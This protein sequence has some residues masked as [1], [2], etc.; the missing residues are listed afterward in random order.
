MIEPLPTD[1]A[2]GSLAGLW[3]RQEKKQVHSVV[4]EGGSEWLEQD[5]LFNYRII[6]QGIP[7]TFP[8]K[9]EATGAF[10]TGFRTVTV[11]FDK[12]FMRLDGDPNSAGEF[13]FAFGAG[14]AETKERLGNVEIYGDETSI[15]DGHTEQ[16]DK[17]ITIPAAPRRLWAQVNALE[18]DVYH[19]PFD[20]GFHGVGMGAS[21]DPPGTYGWEDE[22]HAFASVTEHFDISQTLEGSLETP[23][24]M[25]TGSFAIAFN[26]HGRL[27][28]IPRPGKWLT[29]V[30]K[31]THSLRRPEGFRK[32]AS[33]SIWSA[34]PGQSAVVTS[35]HGH[36][37]RVVLDPD[38]AVYHQE[39][40]KDPRAWR[41]AP[42][43][44]LGGRFEGPLTVVAVG[45]ERVNLFGLSPEGAVL[46]KSHAPDE[47]PDEDWHTLGGDFV[48]PVVA[49]TGADEAIELFATSEDGSVFH[50][51]LAHP[52][53]KQPRG[54]WER[55]GDGI[56]GS[57]AAL[58]S[59][60]T[61]LSLF[62]LG[63]GGEVLHKRRPPRKEQWRPADREWETLGLASGGL[64]SAEWV[65][66]EG[67]L[68][69][70]V[71]QDET[72]RVLAWSAYPE[73]P[74]SEGWQIIGTVNSL[75]QTQ[76]KVRHRLTA[77][78]GDDPGPFSARSEHDKR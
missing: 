72:V 54:E 69:A 26:V 59:P 37:H 32:R 38:G 17:G 46:H 34:R 68:L 53:R 47:R 75:L 40:G 25:S 21:F 43:T 35:A 27:R 20:A 33:R 31:V 74:P 78:A 7:G 48:G 14:D 24:T 13:T 63:R 41:D 36:P 29:S 12:I 44:T 56:G 9:A 66:D 60:R 61:G 73:A 18:D 64:L 57:I 1:Q 6:A 51:A 58:F 71:A 4:F 19:N 70:V 5:T 16:V 3:A 10:R 11:S 23:F 76:G 15:T 8:I 55:V 39:L 62:A 67:L 49:A 22:Y 50:R 52:R 65:G 45:P 77:G 28:V 42:W 2:I 30:P